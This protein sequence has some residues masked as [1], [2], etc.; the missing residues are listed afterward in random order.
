MSRKPTVTGHH[1]EL[2]EVRR[3]FS[4]ELYLAGFFDAARY[5]E[6]GK[7]DNIAMVRQ[8]IQLLRLWAATKAPMAKAIRNV[9]TA[10]VKQLQGKAVL[11]PFV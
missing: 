11:R 3:V 1:L 4:Q 7:F 2:A 8:K 6:W 9:N 10:T 5:Y